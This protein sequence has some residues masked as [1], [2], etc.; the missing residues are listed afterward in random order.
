MIPLRPVTTD[1]VETFWRDGVVCLRGI[2]EPERVR[3]MANPLAAM[4]DT[5]ELANLTAMGDALA[6]SGNSVLRDPKTETKK[7]RFVAGVDHWISHVEFADF[8]PGT[9]TFP[10]S[11]S[12]ARTC[13][14][15]GVRSMWS[16]R[17]L[18]P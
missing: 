4:L 1:E 2:I 8:A 10:I 16:P 17:N 14:P 13:A 9:R 3:A 15:C 6:A 7:G 12:T 5:P 11:T 18:V